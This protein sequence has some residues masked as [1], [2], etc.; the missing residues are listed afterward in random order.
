MEEWKEYKLGEVC[1]ELS[2]GLHKAPKFKIG[3]DYIFVN[4]KNIVNGFI[5]DNDPTKKSSYEEFLK[6]A[7]PLNDTTILYSE[8]SC[9]VAE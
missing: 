1:T 9:A 8:P 7:S 2:D 3:G 4:A 5:V 6:Y